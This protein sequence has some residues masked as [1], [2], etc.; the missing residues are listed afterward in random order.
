MS[1]EDSSV[2][3]GFRGIGR[4]AGISYCD[5]LR[6]ETSDGKGLKTIVTFDA[7]EINRLTEAGQE[8]TTIIQAIN[9]NCHADEVADSNGE[10]YLEVTLEGLK[11]DS[12]FLNNKL[13]S[14]YLGQVAPV[15]F[16][17]RHWSF[18]EKV[19][20][21]AE[22]AG[23]RASL[24]HITIKTF[25]SAG[26][27]LDDIRR[28]HKDKFKIG[29]TGNKEVRVTNLEPLPLVGGTTEDWWG[30]LAIHD[31]DRQLADVTFAGLRI[32]MHN[33]EIGD[34]KLVRE[35][36]TSSP[37]LSM[38]CFG[39]IH[40]TDYSVT[41]NAQRDNFQDSQAWEKIKTR[42]RDDVS[43]LVKRF[44]SASKERN[45]SP[46]VLIRRA[47]KVISKADRAQKQ[48]IES[49]EQQGELVSSL[50]QQK[51]KLASA[52]KQKTRENG[53]K[54]LLTRTCDNLQ[55]QIKKIE[56]V[57][58]TRTD[59]SI[60]HLDKNARRVVKKIFEVLKTE[61]DGDTF[62]NLQKKINEALRPGQSH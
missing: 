21:I 19:Q 7:K 20:S 23:R 53:D 47:E 29:R 25:D 36:F 9:D 11:A 57:K 26:Q 22:E 27:L 41:P 5:T 49:K 32:R 3:A 16:D 12:V 59:D 44:R 56:A 30:W 38:W 10:H 14:K 8:P 15:Q 6:F 40:I 34:H 62:F 31:W 43:S 39:E 1:A 42:I 48:G 61:L 17:P 33:I 52:L 37:H 13:I 18:T 2:N 45:K 51:E 50:N 60:S 58:R 55:N 28:P 46:K 24:D 4:M 54:K 35:L